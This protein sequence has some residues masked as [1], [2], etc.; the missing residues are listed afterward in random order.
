VKL[1]NEYHQT[2]GTMFVRTMPLKDNEQDDEKFDI[3]E[4]KTTEEE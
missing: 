2:G 1:R 3:E 4:A